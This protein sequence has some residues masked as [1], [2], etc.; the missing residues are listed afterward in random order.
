MKSAL[1]PIIVGLLIASIWGY[2]A[3]LRDGDVKLF[4]IRLIVVPLVLLILS[5]I[6]K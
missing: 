2:F 4:I 1:P 3:D 6:S 5:K